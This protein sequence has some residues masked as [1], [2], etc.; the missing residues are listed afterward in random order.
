MQFYFENYADVN[1]MMIPLTI[2]QIGSGITVTT[3][4]LG[5]KYDVPLDDKMFM[6]P[7]K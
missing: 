1:G 6:K 7:A 2:R 4:Y 5:V 3:R